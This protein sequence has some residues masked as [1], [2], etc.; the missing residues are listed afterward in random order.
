MNPC[1]TLS[2]V[3]TFIH[4]HEIRQRDIS[5]SMLMRE[6]QRYHQDLWQVRCH[7]CGSK[8]FKFFYTGNEKLDIQKSVVAVCVE[9]GLG[10]KISKKGK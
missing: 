2:Q 5:L 8:L 9:C 10:I 7:I 6:C 4:T 3:A 1:G